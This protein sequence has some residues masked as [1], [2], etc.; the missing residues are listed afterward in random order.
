LALGQ[1]EAAA[2]EARAA[3]RETE[4]LGAELERERARNVLEEA[5]ASPAEEERARRGGLTRRELEVLRLVAEGLSDGQIAA[6]LVVSEHTVH[7][8]V[9]N[10]R[11]KLGVSSRSAA[12]ARA[13]QDDLL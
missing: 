11:N 7:R 12:V 5:E 3:L 2:R 4:A 1:R 6:R 13:A 10:V 9:A 8:H